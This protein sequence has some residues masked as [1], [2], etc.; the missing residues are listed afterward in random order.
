MKLKR[1]SK[2]REEKPIS[3]FGYNAAAPDGRQWYCKVCMNTRLMDD[4]ARESISRWIELE[5]ESCV[6]CGETNRMKIRSRWVIGHDALMPICF[7]CSKRHEVAIRLMALPIAWSRWM[8]ERTCKQCGHS[9]QA[10]T[11]RPGMCPKCKSKKWDEEKSD[12]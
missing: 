8:R 3:Q 7:R 12:G 6:K 4:N 2:C 1:C 5:P 11:R 10:R 9:W